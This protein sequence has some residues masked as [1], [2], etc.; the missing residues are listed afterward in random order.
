MFVH[1]T[2]SLSV[3]KHEK[4]FCDCFVAYNSKQLCDCAGGWLGSKHQLINWLKG[5]CAVTIF[6]VGFV[7]DNSIQSCDSVYLYMSTVNPR[8][9]AAFVTSDL[10]SCLKSK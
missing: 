5:D 2:N 4:I 7:A 10:F 8:A 9:H 6:C 1:L 3:N